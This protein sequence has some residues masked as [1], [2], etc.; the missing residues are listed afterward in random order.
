M[1]FLL[2]L[3]DYSKT[4]SGESEVKFQLSR[5]TLEPMLRSMAY[6]SDQ[7]STPANRVAVINLKVCEYIFQ[8]CL[9]K[10]PVHLMNPFDRSFFFCELIL[11][12]HLVKFDTLCVCVCVCI[13]SYMK[14]NFNLS[15]MFSQMDMTW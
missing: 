13:R 1:F 15:F 3:Q 10:C 2:Q 7:L 12:I 11:Q 9:I 6:I 14:T 5:V 4:P 8:T